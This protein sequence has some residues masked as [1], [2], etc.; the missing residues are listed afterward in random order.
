MSVPNQGVLMLKVSKAKFR[1]SFIVLL[2]I[3]S[4]SSTMVP[5]TALDLGVNTS[6]LL[7]PQPRL[8]L[9][10]QLLKMVGKLIKST[11]MPLMV[12]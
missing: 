5:T 4:L 3:F 10:Q 7:L 11:T 1:A 12:L 6:S 9:K 8:R 2:T